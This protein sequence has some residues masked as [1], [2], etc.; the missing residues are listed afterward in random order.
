MNKWDLIKFKSFCTTK[1][2]TNKVKRKPT[3]WKKI[4]AKDTTNKELISKIHKKLIQLNT[5]KQ[6]T[7]S[8]SGKGI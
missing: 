1:E 7:Q 6:T 4:I 2:T 5:K 3:E 8:K